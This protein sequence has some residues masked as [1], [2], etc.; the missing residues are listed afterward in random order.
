MKIQIKVLYLLLIATLNLSQVNAQNEIEWTG[1]DE[2]KLMGLFTIWSEAKFA[3]PFFNQIPEVN[4]DIKVQEYIPKVLASKDVE[5]YYKVLMEFSALLNDGHTGVNPPWGPF[6]PGFDYPPM[7]IEI[8]ENKFIITQVGETSEMK[9][10]N[11][12]PGL[13]ILEV[14]NINNEK[15]FEENVLRFN[16]RGTKQADEAINLWT[17][18]QGEKDSK[19]HLKVKDMDGTIRMVDII[20]NSSLNDGS[21]FY[22]QMLRWYMIDPILESKLLSDGIL[23][24]KISNFDK[25]ELITEFKKLIQDIDVKAVNGMIIDLRHNPGGESS[26]AEKMISFL[27]DKPISSAVW[28]IPHYIAADRAWGNDA[29]WTE[30][31]NT[32]EPAEGK[33]YLG[34]LV[35]LTGSGT[36]SSAEDFIVPIH[37]SKRAVLVGE[38]T[39]GSSG[40]PL[41][42]Q[43]P[44]GGNFR[45]VTV[46]MTYP[47]DKEYIG[48]G[49]QPD[50]EIYPTQIDIMNGNDP[51]LVKGIEV[52][53]KW[54]AYI[55]H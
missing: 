33:K 45:V 34:P 3:F 47:D 30:I 14:D 26:I 53:K 20:R 9:A 12:Y 21:N 18:L 15:Y 6:K 42:V 31:K 40:N 39:A 2:Q 7:E 50:E 43:L 11:V 35:I 37:Y 23:Y 41:R 1:T 24:V 8:I 52:L 19:V 36:F 25:E 13:E 17:L 54:E 10:Q 38:K 28:H 44:G 48:I 5:S 29:V 22:C 27:I 32:I 16:K 51:I 55:N 49:I 46:K 4:W